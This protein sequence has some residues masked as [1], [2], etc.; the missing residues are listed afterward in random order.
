MTGI[1][2]KKD[3]K[4]TKGTPTG[5]LARMISLMESGACTRVDIYGFSGGG[6]KYFKKSAVVKD[7][8]I[9]S[10][11]HYIRRLMMATGLRG[12]VCVYGQ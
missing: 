7:E 5:G 2:Y 12:K 6:G 10:V 11:E 8:H 4:I 1:Y 9:I 3:K